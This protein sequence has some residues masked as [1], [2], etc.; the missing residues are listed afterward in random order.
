MTE[1]TP[2]IT[3]FDQLREDP[4]ERAAFEADP[5]QFLADRGWGDLDAGEVREALGFA[6]ESMPIE[7]AVR[8]P[9]FEDDHDG[10]VEAILGGYVEAVST[11]TDLDDESDLEDFGSDALFLDDE[12]ASREGAPEIREDTDDE[13]DEGVET[14]VAAA[15]D[16]EDEGLEFA[17]DE[18]EEHRGEADDEEEDDLDF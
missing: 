3:I 8:I 10:G 6:R 2:L 4:S 9:V 16:F 12:G 17:V 5:G 13:D 7:V 11:E 18:G 14:H 15:D 1:A